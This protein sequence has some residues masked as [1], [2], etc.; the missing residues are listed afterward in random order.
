MLLFIM[1]HRFKDIIVFDLWFR[2]KN[3]DLSVLSRELSFLNWAF[4]VF[5]IL[6]DKV[7]KSVKWSVVCNFAFSRYRL[8]SNVFTSRRVIL[9]LH[10]LITLVIIRKTSISFFCIKEFLSS[11][12]FLMPCTLPSIFCFR[13]VKE[14]KWLVFLGCHRRSFSLS[15]KS[16]KS[17]KGLFVYKFLLTR[18]TL[19]T[20]ESV[21]LAEFCRLNV[22]KKLLRVCIYGLITRH[23]FSSN[24]LFF[25][26]EVLT[27]CSF[28]SYKIILGKKRGV[29]LKEI[30][31]FLSG[32]TR[33][34]NASFESWFSIHILLRVTKFGLLIVAGRLVDNIGRFQL[35]VFLFPFFF[36]FFVDAILTVNWSLLLKVILFTAFKTALW[37]SP[38]FLWFQGLEE[39]LL[40]GLTGHLT[41]CNKILVFCVFIFKELLGIRILF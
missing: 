28:V 41:I 31:R 5:C 19:L 10:F 24:C 39:L 32:F 26:K 12:S 40:C 25:L 14:I 36:F 23:N 16:F 15:S 1:G 9:L 29:P 30:L 33:G 17:L 20:Q 35:E 7:S 2:R 3:W 34:F 11:R 18:C 37:I 21:G 6:I 4:S 22:I 8:S 13:F 38:T 27:C